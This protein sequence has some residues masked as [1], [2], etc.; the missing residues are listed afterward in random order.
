MFPFKFAI[1]FAFM[2]S[3]ILA[4]PIS[5][6]ECDTG[7][8]VAKLISLNIPGNPIEVGSAH[9]VDLSFTGSLSKDVEDDVELVLKIEKQVSVFGIKKWISIPCID[10]YG[11]CTDKLS[12]YW[13]RYNSSFVCGLMTKMGKS[14]S[15]P[16]VAG[17]YSV[18]DYIIP[19]NLDK[20]PQTILNLANGKVKVH[21]EIKNAQT[22]Y[23]VDVTADL[24][25]ESS[26]PSD[27]E[28]EY[29]G[30]SD[31]NPFLSGWFH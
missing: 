14:C 27:D 28:N 25:L 21:I 30:W 16:I 11:S 10:G 2:V 31:Y 26:K 1:F 24:K 9:P 13:T 17:D 7:T 5:Y 29:G 23:C 4:D 8:N 12:E 18:K 6:T 20:L 22:L 15:F 19:V 3:T